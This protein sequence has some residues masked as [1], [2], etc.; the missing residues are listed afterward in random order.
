MRAELR[1]SPAQGGHVTDEIDE[2]VAFAVEAIP[3]DPADFVILA[4]GVV[5]AELRVGDFVAGEDQ[6]QTLRQQ[7]TCK[8]VSTELPAQRNDRRVVGRALMAPIGAVVLVFAAALASSIAL[9]LL[10]V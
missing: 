6:R 10:L 4:I 8:L 1:K 7:Q 2:V 5:V 9:V 3:I